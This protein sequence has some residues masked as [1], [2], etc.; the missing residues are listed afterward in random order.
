MV[1]ATL[2]YAG[3]WLMSIKSYYRHLQQHLWESV[4]VPSFCINIW[5]KTINKEI[6]F[7]KEKD[8]W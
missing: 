1:L 2:Q 7:W 4:F 3:L 6:G 8:F 5:R